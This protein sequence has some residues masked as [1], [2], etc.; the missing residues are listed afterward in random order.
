MTPE[1]RR[2]VEEL[3]NSASH[4]SAAECAIFLATSCGGDSGLRAEVEKL[5][6]QDELRTRMLS[7]TGDAVG[8][9]SPFA[10][11]HHE[12][13]QLG[14]YKI[15]R[16]I[17]AGGMGRVYCAT[18]T[19]LNRK[20]AVKI[21]DEKFSGRFEREARA[22]SAFNHPHI[23]TLYD[24]GPNYLV[25]E[26]LDGSTLADEIKNGPLAIEQVARYGAQ[27]AAALAEAHAHGIVH[28]DLKPGN[29]MMTRHGVKVL[30]FGLAKMASE[31]GLTEANVVMGTPMYM[32]PEQVEGGESDARTDLFAL[33]LVLYEMAVGKLPFV[34]KSLGRM[35]VS[36]AA[37]KAPRLVQQRAEVPETLSALVGKLLERDPAQRCASAGEA[38]AELSELVERLTTPPA[39]TTA[40][41][42]RPAV[43]V[44]A[45]VVLLLAILGGVW[46]YQ[47]SE[48]RRWA[49]EDAIPEI[50]KLKDQEKPLAA[51]LVL[52]NAERTLPGDA[53]L[54]QAARELT[55]F[56][57]VKSTTPGAKVEIQD[58][59][60]PDS[61]WY[62][63]G[64]TPM[65]HV[66]IPKGYFR[67]RLSK[68]GASD[69]IAAPLTG[70]AMQFPFEMPADVKAGMVPVD[71][72]PWGDMIG[73]IG[74][75]RYELPAFDM[76]RFE[77]TN[78]EY[79]KFVDEGGYQKREYWKEKFIKDGTEL[80]W[81]QAMD[82][83]RD[84]TGRPGPSTWQAGH[85]PEGQAEFPVSGV[86]WYEASAY[87]AFVGKSLPALGEW[88]KAAP[89]DTAR[90]TS[91]QSN[92]G[93][94]GAVPVGTSHAVGPY[95][96]YDLTGNVREWCLNSVDGDNRFIL[97]G[98]W[99]TQPYQAYEPEALPPFDRSAMNGFRCVRN[100]QPLPAAT[101]APVVR[102]T[103]NF[104][105]VKPASNEVF[106]AYRGLY[107]YDKRPL[108][109]KAEGVV[110]E[111]AD[112]KKERITIDAG[113]GS[114]R[115]PIY[116]FTPKS[117]RPPYQTVVFFPSARVNFMP[118]SQN[119]GDMDFVD[120]VIESGRSVAYP[121]FRGTYERRPEGTPLPGTVGER[122]LLIQ[123]SKEVRRTLDYLVTRKDIAAG[124]LA[125]LGVS[126][127][128]AE[129]VIFVALDDRF[130]A[131]VFLSGGFF[132]WPLPGGE[133]QTDFAPRMKKPLLMVNG[134]Y[135]FT[136][137]PDQAQ[138]PMFE[139][140]GTAPADKF[141]KVLDT[142]HDVSEL[143][144]E[145][146]K[147]VL[148]F[149]D[150][151]LGRVN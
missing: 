99:G 73:F 59:L 128:A 92:F 82:L 6:T 140:I 52:Q 28:R 94:R 24:V 19:R 5:L 44:P 36:G 137:P 16:L 65:E 74:W 86:S 131:A 149:L 101:A 22:I 96:T 138:A 77:V 97:G 118:S 33:G 147:A 17:G 93:G 71:G 117:V 32:A 122:E 20:V 75:V 116:L 139:M 146:S 31:A 4:L 14:P 67:W 127:G 90:Y 119:L 105:K 50:H 48:K 64:T 123:E 76:D 42:L 108:D 84:P 114:E 111:T 89:A 132:L 87:A 103:R 135:D 69:F 39:S 62:A 38:A 30:D 88:F 148:E 7:L 136:F 40:P 110:E 102:Q 63:L 15:E 11:G 151:Y 60:A 78:R 72:G 106:A 143:K 112:W 126:Q 10:A 115:L 1:R 2:Q 55:T 83:F 70:A 133:D 81:E 68:A 43:L 3:Y 91:N 130:Q 100:R 95:G 34:G 144:P 129:G 23:C 46:L 107:A 109:A 121:I 58:Y 85:S 61:D 57:S 45:A 124:K 141:R 145:L 79:Q 9:G 18:D 25:M 142:P 134:K 80:S 27:I 56:A 37:A 21:T 13:T 29:I 35:Q 49:R 66:R 125:Y 54:A 53:P 8:G 104:S 51:F 113:Y 98:A 150:K 41:L 26:L 120:Y 47:R 12:N